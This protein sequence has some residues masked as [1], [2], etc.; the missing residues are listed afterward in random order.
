MR[1]PAVPAAKL[2]YVVTLCFGSAFFSFVQ[3][4][5]AQSGTQGAAQ[6]PCTT[7]GGSTSPQNGSTQQNNGSLSAETQNMKD[8]AKQLGSLF[9]KKPTT[10]STAATPS[11]CPVPPSADANSSAPAAA[12][13]AQAASAQ[14]A[15][16]VGGSPVPAPLAAPTGPLDPAKL[17]DVLGI[18]LGTPRA[19][20]SAAFLK[21]Y[22]GNPVRPEG[23]DTVAGMSMIN[24]DLPGKSGSDNVHLEF[25]LT[26]GKQ[27][28]YYIERSV[29]YK[30]QMS[31][32][33]VMASLHQKYGQQ[34]YEDANGGVMF[35]F[36]DEQGH[37]IPADN[38]AQ[39]RQAHDPYGCDA[40]D[41]SEK[42]LFHAQVN[43]YLH[44]ALGPATFCDS[45]IILRVTVAEDNLVDRI[46]TVLEDRA[47]LRR[48]VTTYAEAQKVQN[49][50]QQQQELN[51]ANEAKPNL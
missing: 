22:P 5:N 16:A 47:L 38:D 30:Q 19:D 50:K 29:F 51:K 18:H 44:N 13:A 36:F 49:Q 3:A 6:S 48:E 15:G 1:I 21:L 37:Q 8:A 27:Q 34:I 4:Q 45:I 11:P 23:P 31:R 9:K 24:I 26:P 2:I 28:V 43:S 10:S 14:P 12:P 17:P 7:A 25:T 41:A 40:D 33:N 35:W 42:M 46:F 32:A 20:A 39:R